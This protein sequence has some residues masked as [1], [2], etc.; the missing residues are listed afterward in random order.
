MPDTGTIAAVPD[1]EQLDVDGG[2]G[3]DATDRPTSD[4]RDEAAA[5]AAWYDDPGE[6]S[7]MDGT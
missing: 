5:V 3:S 4:D 7:T 2:V 6:V 1:D